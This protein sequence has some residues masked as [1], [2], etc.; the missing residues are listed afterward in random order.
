M[1]MG[2]KSGGSNRFSTM[3][4]INVT[5]L[6]DIMLV[7]LIIF[8]VTAPLMTQGVDIDLP[9]ADGKAMATDNEPMVVSVTPDGRLFIEEHPVSTEELGIKIAAIRQG[10]PD[11]TI[12]VR[13]DT[14]AAYGTVIQVMA[15]LQ[16]AGVHRI[17]L[18]TEP[19]TSALPP[20]QTP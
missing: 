13:G 3:S 20:R 4:D 1:A 10:N 5:P 8:M 14:T 19:T 15:Q 7:L 6:V 2:L 9:D 18:V 11:L 16:Q 17:G 12:Y